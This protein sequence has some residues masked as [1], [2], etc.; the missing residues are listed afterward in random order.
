MMRVLGFVFA[1]LL[2]GCAADRALP[3]QYDFEGTPDPVQ[4]Q[5]PLDATI[6]IPSIAAPPWL[7]TTAL[8]YRLGYESPAMARTYALSQW[9]SPPADLLTRRLRQAIEASNGGITLAR[10]SLASDGYTLEIS[11][12]T[13]DQVFSSPKRSRCQVVLR[14]TLVRPGN[15]VIA[16]RTF[17]AERPAPS[18]DAAGGV[19]GLVAA[20]DV[21]IRSIIS[22][23]R[24][25]LKTPPTVAATNSRH[26][27][28]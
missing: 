9:V 24:Q 10:P 13:F 4:L 8:L 11:L 12:D 5:V 27:P 20:T 17:T 28:R 2:A 25:M 22:W 6:A 19:E 16:Q 26:T 7:R 23:L 18:P 3:V 15:D 21:D 1:L 14:A